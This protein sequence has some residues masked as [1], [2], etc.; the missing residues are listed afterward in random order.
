[1]RPTNDIF[2]PISPTPFP[3]PTPPASPT[4]PIPRPEPIV[5]PGESNVPTL[6]DFPEL[7]NPMIYDTWTGQQVADWWTAQGNEGN[8][9]DAY[10]D[11]LNPEG[12]EDFD[13]S[14]Y[15]GAPVAQMSHYQDTPDQY[16]I[17]KVYPEAY[18]LYRLRS[19]NPEDWWEQQGY[20]YQDIEQSEPYQ[21][22]EGLIQQWL[23][24]EQQTQDISG[25]GGYAAQALGFG[26]QGE[27]TDA[28][29]SLNQRL[30]EV[31]FSGELSEDQRRALSLDVQNVR[32]EN[33]M[34]LEAIA[35]EGRHAAAFY[36]ADELSSQVADMYIQGKLKYMEA[37]LIRSQVEFDAMQRQ[38]ESMVTM[39]MQGAEQYLSNLYNNR[40]QALQGYATQISSLV[41][42][43][44]QYIGLY[45]Q[46][47]NQVYQSIMAD[48]GFDEHMMNQ[49]QEAYEAYVSP[50]LDQFQLEL[51]QYNAWLAGQQLEESGGLNLSGA[52]AGA[53]TGAA[54]GSAVAPGI[55]TIVGALLGG[56]L[57][58]F[59]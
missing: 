30:S 59:T 4:P 42:Q 1:M 5:T 28:L 46:H 40:A 23:S 24:P 34:M 26:S 47:V 54:I 10:A 11:I 43:N 29:S 19:E 14:I 15:S 52:L 53:G 6:G 16:E 32:Q 13:Y 49:N 35:A 20:D 50:Y 8:W 38:Y 3:A 37:N 9:W 17:S 48:M 33:M 36:K 2:K 18:Q 58:L 39:G 56:L 41:A 45:E 55:G 27:M 21:G 44:A 25:A 12:I 51:D 31:D 22:M 57:G 7:Q